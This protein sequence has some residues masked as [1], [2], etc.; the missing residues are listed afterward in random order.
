M[1]ANTPD[2]E[3]RLLPRWRTA[4]AAIAL[5][6]LKTPANRAPPVHAVHFEELLAEWQRT[7]TIETAAELVSSGWALNRLPDVEAAARLLASDQADATPLLRDLSRR[8]LEGVAPTQPGPKCMPVDFTQDHT[9][10]FAQIATYKRRARRTPRNPIAWMDLAHAH[11][12]VGQQE[13][14]QRAVRTALAL[15][16]ENRF[17]LRSAA[18]F[19]VHA[20]DVEQALAVLRKA[21]SLRTDPWLMASEIALSSVAQRPPQ[22]Y[23]RARSIIDADTLDPWHT[24]ELHG[25]LGTLALVDRGVGKARKFFVKSLRRPTEN[26]VAQAQWAANSNVALEVPSRL[27]TQ[28]HAFEA[29]ALKARNERRWKDAIHAC[30][31]W[32][33]MEPTSSRPLVMGAFI[34]EVALDDGPTALEFT[35]RL[36]LT[37]PNDDIALNN[38]IVALAYAGRQHDAQQDFERFA[39]RS[40][41]PEHAIVRRATEGLLAFRGGDVETGQQLYMDAFERATALK[42]RGL[43]ALV[44]WHLIREGARVGL[45]GVEETM[46]ELWKHTQDIDLPE[47]AAMHLGVQTQLAANKKQEAMLLPA[48]RTH[49]PP[50]PSGHF[51]HFGDDAHDKL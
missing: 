29:L 23:K 44:L 50:L 13:K 25:A 15:A 5:G 46:A 47:L 27:L 38:H 45:A 2:N 4:A 39:R 30:R 7:P 20:H 9:Q 40:L 8:A 26:A 22:S 49:F 24:G 19:F 35:Q 43:S 33:A 32:S 10:L 11:T 41:T 48:A 1:T 34:A 18:R 31:Q 51:L 42:D 6:E 17:V 16:P 14:A 28:D 36:L 37:L 12:V 3:R 21:S